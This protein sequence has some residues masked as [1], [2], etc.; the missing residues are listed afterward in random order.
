MASPDVVVVGGGIIGCSVAWH[1]ARAGAR[2]AVVERGRV[3]GQASGAAAGMLAPISEAE[4]PGAFLELGLRSLAM[5]PAVAEELREETG[6]DVEYVRSGLLRVA[7]DEAEAEALARRVAWQREAGLAVRWLDA[8]EARAVEPAAG[9]VAAAAWYAE[10][11]H[12]FSPRLVQAFAMAAARRGVRF[13]EGTEVAGFLTEG[14]RVTGVRLAGGGV[15]SLAA[16]HVVVAAGAWTGLCGRWLAAALP[17]AP[18]RGQIIALQQLPPALKGIVFSD[19]GYA[20]AKVDGTVVVGATEDRAGFD[21]RVTAAGVAYLSALAP[22][23][24]AGLEAA[25]FRH[26]WAGLRPWSAD[27]LPLVGPVPGWRGVTVASGHYRNGILLSPVT[28]RMVADALGGGAP[29]PAALDPGRFAGSVA[30]AAV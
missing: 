1:L 11:H 8:A 22:R 17:V 10:E 4:G 16:G 20:V 12:V 13:L 26:A 18:V 29:W 28:G 23:L 25:F 27:G 3:G 14:D 6:I 19:R 21:N 2:V 24:G 9:E 30:R 7:L 5:F 15:E